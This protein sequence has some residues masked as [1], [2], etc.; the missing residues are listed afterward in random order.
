MEYFDNVLGQSVEAHKEVT[1]ETGC[2]INLDDPETFK[3]IF[4]KETEAE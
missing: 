4:V 2:Y 3:D 1:P